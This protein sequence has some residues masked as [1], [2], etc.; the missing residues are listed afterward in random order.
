MTRGSCVGN[1]EAGSKS[2]RRSLRR[3][4]PMGDNFLRQQISN[5]TKKRDRAVAERKS[6]RLF[7]RPELVSTLYPV[8]PLPGQQLEK[9]EVLFGV[10]S[11]SNQHIDVARRQVKVGCSEGD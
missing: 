6:P 2:I 9:G 4:F 11:K 7:D 1:G 5:F 8:N 10:V 3:S